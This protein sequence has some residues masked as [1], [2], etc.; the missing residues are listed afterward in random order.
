MEHREVRGFKLKSDCLE[1]L[2]TRR[3]IRKFKPDQ[4]PKE[5][6]LKILDVARYAPSTRNAQPWIFIIITD[7]KVK[8]ELASIHARATPLKRS[9]RV[10]DSSDRVTMNHLLRLNKLNFIYYRFVSK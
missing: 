2:L 1:L 3:S 4:I 6:I 7:E 10:S 9:S 5:T 8:N